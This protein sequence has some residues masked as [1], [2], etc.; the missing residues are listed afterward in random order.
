MMKLFSFLLLSSV[1]LSLG[2]GLHFGKYGESSF[3]LLKLHLS[4]RV[5]AL[6]GAGSALT[7]SALEAT[8]LNPASAYSDSN[9]LYLAHF[10]NNKEF[11]AKT[12]ALTWNL[13]LY[14]YKLFFHSRYIGFGD[15]D[16]HRADKSATLVAY[17]AHTLKVQTGLAGEYLNVQWGVAVSYVE[18]NIAFANYRTVVGDVGLLYS[19][20]KNLW[21]GAGVNNGDI[22]TSSLLNEKEKKPIPPTIGRVGLAYLYSVTKEVSVRMVGDARTRNDEKLTFPLGAEV[23]CFD[24]ITLRTGYP[25]LEP[26]SAQDFGVAVKAK[27]FELD[28]SLQRHAALSPQHAFLLKIYY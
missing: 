21:I 3:Q 8:E 9:A 26:E 12:S 2:Q 15:I 13:P 22:W 20:F 24:M 18:N 10:L 11:G 19:P 6:G 17:G 23:I 4:P 5:V 28:Y 27:R 7:G 16:G 14:S 1:A 25:V